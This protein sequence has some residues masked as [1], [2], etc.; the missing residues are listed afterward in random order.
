[1]VRLLVIEIPVTCFIGQY[2]SLLIQT[3]EKPKSSTEIS[4]KQPAFPKFQVN[5]PV[6]KSK[7]KCGQF[8][9]MVFARGSKSV[10]GNVKAFFATSQTS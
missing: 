8:K 4:M 5:T 2:N 9:L 7:E 6:V 3:I 10:K 1:M